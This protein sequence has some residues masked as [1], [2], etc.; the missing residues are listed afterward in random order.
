MPKLILQTQTAIN[1]MIAAGFRRNEFTAQTK[2]NKWG[3]WQ[4][5]TIDVKISKRRKIEERAEQLTENGFNV[6]I[7]EGDNGFI[8]AHVELTYQKGVIKRYN[9]DVTQ[10][11]I[12]ALLNTV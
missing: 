12:D 2:K 5:P 8:T 11:R 9:V 6:E 3:E 1:G 10:R 4:I 7:Y